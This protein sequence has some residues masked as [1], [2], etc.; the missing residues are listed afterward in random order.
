MNKTIQPFAV[1]HTPNIPEIL[2]D[3]KFT[4][5]LSTFQAGKVI[6]LSAVNR[7]KLIQLP[8]TFSNAMGIATSGTKMAIACKHQ[9]EV[10]IN[11]PELA[12]NYPV[13]RNTY[14]SLFV[15]KA[16]FHTGSL[17]LHDM[18]FVEGRLLAVNTLF[19][20]LAEIDGE[21]S[22]RPVWQ[23]SFITELAPEDRCHLNG[24]AVS[25]TEVKYVTALGDTD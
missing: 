4:L 19:S 2:H 12:A 17:D 6:F 15:P 23:P 10:L 20:C 3:L 7:E 8:R 13:Q 22:F 21:Y 9:V 1:I 18:N 5:A 16:S 11:F 24:M 25:G 14:D